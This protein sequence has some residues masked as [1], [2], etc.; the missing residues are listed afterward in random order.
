MAEQLFQIGI[1]A[2]VRNDKG[3]ILLLR[4]EGTDHYKTFWDFPGGRMQPGETFEQTLERELLEEIGFSHS[5]KPVLVAA[6]MANHTIAVGDTRVPL[7]LLAYEVTLPPDASITLGEGE[8]EYRLV[9][10]AE[11][12]E[13]LADKYPQEFRDTLAKL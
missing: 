4:H 2:V 5:A 9:Q 13:L 7:I 1:K 11:A 12:A 8:E 3:E 6:V 10:P